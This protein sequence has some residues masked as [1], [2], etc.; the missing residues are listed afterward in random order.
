MPAFT[1][2][3][4]K[5]EWNCARILA[6]RRKKTQLNYLANCLSFNLVGSARCK[7]QL[8]RESI[9]TRLVDDVVM[10]FSPLLVPKNLVG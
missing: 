8:A 9:D 6:N 3:P 7:H 5:R 4:L 2:F 1:A 10:P